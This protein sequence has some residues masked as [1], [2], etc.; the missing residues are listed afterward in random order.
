MN[1]GESGEEDL[2]FCFCDEAFGSSS[3]LLL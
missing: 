2:G 1:K 3:L